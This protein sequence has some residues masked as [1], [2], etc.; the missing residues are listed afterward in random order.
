MSIL[1]S[2]NIGVSGLRAA[3]SGMGVVGDNIANSGT[4]G[5]KASRAEF[6]DVLASS[7]SGV[8]GADQMGAGVRLGHIKTIMT[9]GDLTRTDNITDLAI[10]GGGFFT[11]E[12][13]LDAVSQEMA[14]FTLIRMVFL[15]MVMETIF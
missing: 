1:R 15:L 11:V 7:L 6:Q 2:F 5:F 12:T 8:S 3:G 9:Q 4:N 14:L 13:L 10:N